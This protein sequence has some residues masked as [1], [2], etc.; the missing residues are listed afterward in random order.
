MERWE[1]KI[2]RLRQHLRGQEKNVSDAYKKEKKELLDKLD[3]LDKKVEG[4]LLTL[5]EIDLK[6]CLNKCLTQLL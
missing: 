6:C 4:T 1:A 3:A 5:Y 2:K